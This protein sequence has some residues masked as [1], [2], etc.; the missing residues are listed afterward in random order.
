MTP[1]VSKHA[2]GSEEIDNDYVEDCL[3]GNFFNNSEL[4]VRFA[5]YDKEGNG[6]ISSSDLISFLRCIGL[7]PSKAECEEYKRNCSGENGMV[8]FS[9][10]ASLVQ[11]IGWDITAEE[12]AAA[13][14]LAHFDGARTGYIEESVLRKKLASLGQDQLTQTELTRMISL[15]EKD[16]KGRVNINELSTALM[17]RSSSA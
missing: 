11:N 17:R 6:L 5:W 14:A 2:Q 1:C 15:V 16:E 10:V 13:D 3:L 7:N 12:E 9:S 4:K 8:D